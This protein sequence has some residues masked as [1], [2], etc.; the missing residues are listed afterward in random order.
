LSAPIDSALRIDS[1]A[2]SGPMVKIVT[3][4]SFPAARWASAICRP[5]SMAYSSSSLISPSTDARS[6]VPSG[7]SL[8]SAQVSGTCL[9]HTTMFIDD[10]DLLVRHVKT[11]TKTVK[12]YN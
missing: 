1:A 3:S 7:L 11:R 8:R 10:T 2:F 6:S 12:S 9:T 4:A 5:S